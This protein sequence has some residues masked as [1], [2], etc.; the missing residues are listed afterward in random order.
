M[1]DKLLIRP[2]ERQFDFVTGPQTRCKGAIVADTFLVEIGESRFELPAEVRADEQGPF[3]YVDPTLRELPFGYRLVVEREFEEGEPPGSG[4]SLSEW[5][6]RATEVQRRYPA[7]NVIV[8][9]VTSIALHF[10]ADGRI[11]GWGS[12]G[13]VEYQPQGRH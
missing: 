1:S 4:I 5:D 13:P 12:G 3:V 9:P 8:P 7:H 11:D 2:F 10:N 6:P